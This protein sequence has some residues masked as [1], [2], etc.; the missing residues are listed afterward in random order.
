MLLLVAILNIRYL[1]ISQ[2]NATV[3]GGN[4]LVEMQLPLNPPSE[5]VMTGNQEYFMTTIDL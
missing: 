5:E 3:I 4:K 2:I 1:N